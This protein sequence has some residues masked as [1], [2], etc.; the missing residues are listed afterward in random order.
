MNIYTF[1]MSAFFLGSAL[2][3]TVSHEDVM[4]QYIVSSEF[5]PGVYELTV[6][7]DL[8]KSKEYSPDG[9]LAC[10]GPYNLEGSVIESTLSCTNDTHWVQKI[11]L[12][13]VDFKK[14]DFVAMVSSSLFHFMELPMKFSRVGKKSADLPFAYNYNYVDD[15]ASELA[16]LKSLLS[17]MPSWYNEG[18]PC[19]GAGWISGA[20]R[21]LEDRL[22]ITAAREAK[23][24]AEQEREQSLKKERQHRREEEQKRKDEQNNEFSFAFN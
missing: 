19:Y 8:V 21:D 23:R 2:S 15:P 11:D 24:K 5:A 10:Q 14:D 7:K 22:G 9:V 6:E 3:A 4:G 1:F 12:D 16:R 20:I 13:G 17:G 18:M